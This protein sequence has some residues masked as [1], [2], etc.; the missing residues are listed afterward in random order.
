VVVGAGPAGETVAGRCADGGLSVALVEWELVGGECSYWGRIPS[1]TLIL[2]GDVLAAAARVPGAREAVTGPVDASAALAQRSVMTSHRDD[3]GQLPW[4]V[5]HG[6]DL[7]RGT[8][9]LAGPRRVVVTADRRAAEQHT[10]ERA[11]VLAIGTTAAIPRYQVWPRRP[12]GTTATR[13][14]PRACPAGCS[15]WAVAPFTALAERFGL[16]NILGAFLAGVVVAVVDRDTA[17]HPHF[18]TK[19]EAIG[20]GFLIPVFFV[21]SGARLDLHGLF[22]SPSAL[23]RVPVFLAALLVTR[24]VP[25]VLHVRPSGAVPRP[26]L[27]CSRPRR[28]RSSSPPHRSARSSAASPPS[29]EPPWSAPGCCPC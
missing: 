9:R 24:G 15:S 16:E 27:P 22:A 25:A 3:S 13:P 19:L 8:A 7:V 20:F 6:V 26:P 28:C 12:R 14:R 23:L 10:A 11:V 2:P 29:P 5:E 4:L 18:R 21:A 1:R 17:G